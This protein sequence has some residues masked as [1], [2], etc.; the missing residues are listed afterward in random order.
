MATDK[1]KFTKEQVS[2]GL[3]TL[4]K[5]FPQV[6]TELQLVKNRELLIN[7]ILNNT[8]T[9]PS[10]ELAPIQS[11]KK[12]EFFSGS[13]PTPSH[14]LAHA[15]SEKKAESFSLSSLPELTPC[16]NACGVV[17][18]DVVMFII[19]LF[20]LRVSNE[21]R[22]TREI[23]RELGG[24]TLRGFARSIDTFS[25]S[26][27]AYDKAKA[28]FTL[29]GEVQNAGGFSIVFKVLKDE[30]S[31]W[32]WVKTGAIAALQITAWFAS[33]GAAFIAEVALNIMSAE[34]LIEDSVKATK[35]CS[36]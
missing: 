36:K 33:D 21:E 34:Q 3:D 7:H 16:Q 27:G 28:L 24:D 8:V 13:S 31:W 22:L 4:M 26:T 17:I 23:I 15:Q 9:A 25:T 29:F 20:G 12:A 14:E 19:G 11:G 18:V 30:M 10:L 2:E 1:A 5:W 32:D 35:A 6:A